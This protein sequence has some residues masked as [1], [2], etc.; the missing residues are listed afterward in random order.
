M[1]K[2]ADVR[3]EL[4]YSLINN[5]PNEIISI[6][7]EKVPVAD[8]LEQFAE[9]FS[10]IKLLNKF[11]TLSKVEIAACFCAAAEFWSADSAV[12]YEVTRAALRDISFDLT[13]SNFKERYPQLDDAY[14]RKHLLGASDHFRRLSQQDTL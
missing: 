7:K 1:P 2:F 9:D 13:R 5:N 11:P 6:G 14:L 10:P 3:Q 12:P 4:W 8:V